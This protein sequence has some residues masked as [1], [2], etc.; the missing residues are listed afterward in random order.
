MSGNIK[1]KLDDNVSG[2]NTFNFKIKDSD[3]AEA[4]LNSTFSVYA[5]TANFA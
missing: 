4:E 1:I 2:M 5:N 3:N